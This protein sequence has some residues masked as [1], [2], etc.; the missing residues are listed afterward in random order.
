MLRDVRGDS[1]DVIEVLEELSLQDLEEEN[2]AQITQAV[3]RYLA[4]WQPFE[5]APWA[6]K[7]RGMNYDELMDELRSIID[8]R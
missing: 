4:G 1:T 6:V 2:K 5:S 8:K 7:S 3:D